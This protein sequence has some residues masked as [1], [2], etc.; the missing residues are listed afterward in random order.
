MIIHDVVQGSD[1]WKLVRLGKFTAS[2]ADDL[3]MDKNKAGYRNLLN[4]IVFEKITGVEPEEFKSKWMERGNLIEEEART[5]YMLESGLWVEKVGFVELD[6]YTGASPDGFIG[7][8]GLL[9]IKCP[10]SSTLIEYHL[11]GTVP[12]P[13][14][15]VTTGEE[16][17]TSAPGSLTPH[18]ALCGVHHTPIPSRM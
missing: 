6:E 12:T 13:D 2:N 1:Q 7:D 4:R 5:A 17:V 3:L 10:S 16:G 18:W 14:E 15:V 11:S 9:E 8:D